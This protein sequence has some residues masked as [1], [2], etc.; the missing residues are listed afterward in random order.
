MQSSPDHSPTIPKKQGGVLFTPDTK[1]VGNE[2]AKELS[3]RRN[4][5]TYDRRVDDSL[6]EVIE[7]KTGSRYDVQMA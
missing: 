3:L 2:E 4:E 1:A 6:L 5:T 7:E